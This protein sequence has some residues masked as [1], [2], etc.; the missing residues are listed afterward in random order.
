MRPVVLSFWLS[1]DGYSCNEGTELMRF[2]Q[3]ADDDA[4]QDEYGVSRLRQAGT[5]IMGR[6]TYEGWAKYWP[7]SDH[8]AAEL[9][10]GTPKVVFSKTLR[11]ADWPGTRIAGGDTAEEIARLKAEPGGEII[12]H[13]GVGFAR[14]LIQLGLVDEYRLLVLP[15]AVGQGDRLFT[16]LDRLLPLRLITSKSFSTGLLELTYAP[17]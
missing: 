2:M 15:A 3:E 4:E 6:V 5:H 17:A 11:S 7:E 1:V 10:N 13:G 16:G 14:S 8:P 9:L 12:A